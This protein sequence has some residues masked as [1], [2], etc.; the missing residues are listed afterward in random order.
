MW[1]NRLLF[2]CFIMV[3]VFAN[4]QLDTIVELE[5]VFIEPS[6][7]YVQEVDLEHSALN[8]AQQ[9]IDKSPVFIKD[10][11]AGNLATIT[12]QGTTSS[13]SSLYWNG[14]NLNP[15]NS[16]TVDY[17]LVDAYLFKSFTINTS[18]NMQQ[19]S[20][21]GANISLKDADSNKKGWGVKGIL[22][23]GTFND[24]KGG[25]RLL[26]SD[27]LTEVNLS[28]YGGVAQNNFRFFNPVSR[29]FQEQENNRNEHLA[30]LFQFKRQLNKA[31]IYFKSWNR[32]SDR[33]LPSPVHV[34]NLK[35]TQR[36]VYS[37]NIFG[38]NKYF[39]KSWLKGHLA[40]LNES[41]EY[42]N[43]SADILGIGKINRLQSNLSYGTEGEKYT[44][45]GRSF[46]DFQEA[47]ISN[48]THTRKVI[49]VA[50]D[51]SYFIGDHLT[52]KGSVRKEVYLAEQNLPLLWEAKLEHKL[53]QTVSYLSFQK[54][55]R[56]PTL[57]DLY[58]PE[59]GNT[60]L[61]S[62]VSNTVYFGS[63]FS[64]FVDLSAELFYGNVSQMIIWLPESSSGR[65]T[66]QNETSINRRGVTLDVSK[67]ISGKAVNIK[68]GLVWAHTISETAEGNQLIYTP[69]N[70][71]KWSLNLELKKMFYLQYTGQW[72]SKSYVTRDL[73]FSLPSYTVSN[74]EVGK[75]WGDKIKLRTSIESRNLFGYTYYVIP[76]RAL[77]RRY[78]GLKLELI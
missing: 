33:Q 37:R 58:W 20:G 71:V 50:V 43:P 7:K 18:N 24:F 9:L 34:E 68:P 39:K 78:I 44:V 70:L 76:F 73:S 10:Y 32:I 30:G 56:K 31:E 5:E 28:F 2:S 16:G 46:V 59:G 14:I 26:F 74:L 65:W 49:G 47:N 64:H 13:Q 57:N 51:A 55:A 29:E 11:G 45:E 75:T 22:K 77:P 17:S 66:P 69:K 6:K 3:G 62:E 41:F 35:E 60:A 27:S 36:D 72:V 54:N 23:G 1:R 53:K 40:Y 52:T 12:Y 61:N 38:I 42:H 63:K 25:M 4:A 21:I 67:E 15:V 8:L 48:N 19:G